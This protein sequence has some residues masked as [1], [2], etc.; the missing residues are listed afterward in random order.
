MPAG[1]FVQL[2]LT[3][4]VYPGDDDIKSITL[5]MMGIRIGTFGKQMK[6]SGKHIIFLM[7]LLTSQFFLT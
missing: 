2:F 1:S 7:P 3:T 5:Q 6:W 4:T